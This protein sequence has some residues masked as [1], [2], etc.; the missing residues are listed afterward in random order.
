MHCLICAGQ[1]NLIQFPGK[2]AE[3]SAKS[4]EEEQRKKR[5]GKKGGL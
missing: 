2:Y 5:K 3:K 4:Q 1:N